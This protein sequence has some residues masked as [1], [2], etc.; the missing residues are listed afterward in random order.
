MNKLMKKV[1][2]L[3]QA[4]ETD[5]KNFI[6]MINDD[7]YYVEYSDDNIDELLASLVEHHYEVSDDIWQ[8]HSTC[9][10]LLVDHTL[11]KV[12]LIQGNWLRYVQELDYP[13][14]PVDTLIELLPF[15]E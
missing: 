13:I 8:N 2:E 1:Q 6:E 15:H 9:S 11:K 14:H 5:L 7:V 4:L 10:H 12:Q 3:K